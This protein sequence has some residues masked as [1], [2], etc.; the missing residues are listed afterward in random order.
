MN[1][2]SVISIIRLLAAFWKMTELPNLWKEQAVYVS[3]AMGFVDPLAL[4][5]FSGY[6]RL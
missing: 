3:S 2:R 6:Y 4:G 1:S 5:S